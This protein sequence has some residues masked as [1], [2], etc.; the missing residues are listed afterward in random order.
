MSNQPTK[1]QLRAYF[2]VEVMGESMTKA[3]VIIGIS[4]QAVSKRLE[5]FHKKNATPQNI[6]N[7]LK[8]LE[9]NQ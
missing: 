7:L 2:L 1:K 6:Y 9:L 8:E 4:R 3:G 5:R